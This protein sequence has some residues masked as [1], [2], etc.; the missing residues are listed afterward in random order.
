ML[1]KGEIK[2]V[3]QCTL[4][5]DGWQ[6]RS[7]HGCGAQDEGGVHDEVHPDYYQAVEWQT[8]AEI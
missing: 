2:V 8:L 5:G 6:Q 3:S 7:E 1:A 4:T